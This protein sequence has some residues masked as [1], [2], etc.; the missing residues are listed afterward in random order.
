MILFYCG[1]K[2][3]IVSYVCWKITR[4]VT[5]NELEIN[6]LKKKA[7]SN[8]FVFSYSI[9]MSDIVMKFTV[10]I[11]EIARNKYF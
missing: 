9:G 11:Q 7:E 1:L 10:K 3:N 5:R 2:E 6:C 8:D 4:K